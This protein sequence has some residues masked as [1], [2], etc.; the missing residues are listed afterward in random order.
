MIPLMPTSQFPGT[1]DVDFSR[2]AQA[3]KLKGSLRHGQQTK[4]KKQSLSVQG[5]DIKGQSAESLV[6]KFLASSN[7]HCFVLSNFEI[8]KFRRLFCCGKYDTSNRFLHEVIK[9]EDF[10][11]DFLI[12]HANAGIVAI[13]CKSTEKFN[14]QRYSESK[15]QLEKKDKFLD[16][17][18]KLMEENRGQPRGKKIPVKKVISFPFVDMQQDKKDPYNLGRN[19]LIHQPPQSWWSFLLAQSDCDSNLLEDPIYQDM[20]KFIMGMYDVCELSVGQFLLKSFEQIKTQKFYEKCS[21]LPVSVRNQD[22]LHFSDQLIFANPEQQEFLKSESSRLILVGEFGTG[23][24]TMV[25]EKAL[26]EI[27]KGRKVAISAP[28][29]L[30]PIQNCYGRGVRWSMYSQISRGHLLELFRKIQRFGCFYRRV[31]TLYVR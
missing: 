7:Q 24:S 27:R 31:S 19:A 3:S 6:Q 16:L 17:V 25:M 14:P 13:E 22:M 18:Q 15:Q 10:E 9:M 4:F 1:T 26:L 29:N 28:E 30:M 5:M 12:F 21:A 8:S 20:I 23:K 2:F 11:T